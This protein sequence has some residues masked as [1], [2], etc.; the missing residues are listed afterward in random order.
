MIGALILVLALVLVCSWT[1]ATINARRAD[2]RRLNVEN[3]LPALDRE[4]LFRPELYTVEGNEYRRRALRYYAI[5]T[6]ALAAIVTIAMIAIHTT[7][8][9]NF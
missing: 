7:G 9:Y 1:L 8:R 3:W 5:G 6:I 4:R 2:G